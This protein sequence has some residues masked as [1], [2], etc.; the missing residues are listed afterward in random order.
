MKYN[1]L[2][3]VG[4]ICLIPIPLVFVSVLFSL[5]YREWGAVPVFLGVLTI[6]ACVGMF[7][8]LKARRAKDVNQRKVINIPILG[9]LINIFIGSLPYVFLS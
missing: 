5:F 6:Q 7:C 1:F 4:L 9:L 3:Y 8:I 2:Y